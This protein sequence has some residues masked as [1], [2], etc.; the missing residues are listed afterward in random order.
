M[1]EVLISLSI[2]LGGLC[3]AAIVILIFVLEKNKNQGVRDDK[4]SVYFGEI[5][6]SLQSSLP[7]LIENSVQEAYGKM[8]SEMKAQGETDNRRLLEF[9]GN[10]TKSLT[11]SLSSYNTSLNGRVD[12]MR[13]SLNK[14]IGELNDKVDKN[15]LDLNKQ[16][17]DS[18]QSGFKGTSEAMGALQ[19]RLAKIDEAQKN[20]KSLQNDVI[21]LNNVLTNSQSRGQYG[22]L[23]L[24]MLLEAT[25]P[26]GKGKLYNLQD[27]L[28]RVHDGEKVR[29]DA[30]IVFTV[31]G[32]STKLCIDSK[33]PFSPYQKLFERSYADEA[34]RIALTA[35]F[36][37]SIKTASDDIKDK[38][39]IPG[40]T[41]KYAIMFLPND[42]VF[43]FVENEFASLVN[44]MRSNG[45]ILA[46]PSTLQ[47]IIV[48]FHSAALDAERNKDL[49]LIDEALKSLG[50]DFSRFAKRWQDLEKGLDSV[51]RR[52]K[53][54]STSVNKISSRFDK[55][56]QNELSVIPQEGGSGRDP[57][58]IDDEPSGSSIEQSWRN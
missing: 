41:A 52:A 21:S 44:E 12:S 48:I 28:G 38:Y 33:F 46:C 6:T 40:V 45:V 10:V 25:F 47:A 32:E 17:G 4:S 15:L 42:G 50:C 34:E 24:E 8:Q 49:A 53:D 1:N 58:E 5:K 13:D 54:F 11:E 27:D 19:E 37:N 29:P 36:K 26:N 43:A 51:S 20:L 2:A 30:D 23:Q 9:Q 39:I 22:E 14:A 18:L 55:I 7:L 56:S 3:L 31:A 35:Q 16:V 57:I